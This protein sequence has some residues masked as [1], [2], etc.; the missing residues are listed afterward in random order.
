[1]NRSV[2]IENLFRVRSGTIHAADQELAPGDTP[3]V[4]CGDVNH[5]LVGYFKIPEEQQYE[6][7]LTVAYNGSPL[8]A[9]YRPYRFWCQ[10]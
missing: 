4:S 9:K 5:G 1:M 2:M 3:L 8:T 7:A 6:D 10:R